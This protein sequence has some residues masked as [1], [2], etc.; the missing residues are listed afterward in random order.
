M[1]F[2]FFLDCSPRWIIKFGP[3][4]LSVRK[5]SDISKFDIK[6]KNLAGTWKE[7]GKN[8]LPRRHSVVAK[9]NQ[10]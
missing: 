1:Q 8:F 6:P 5:V 3:L 2:P 10:K 7:L 4:I 9:I